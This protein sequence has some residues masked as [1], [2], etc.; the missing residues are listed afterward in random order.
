MPNTLRIKRRSAGGSSGSPASLEQAELAYNESD[1]GNGILYIGIGTGG[2]GGSA[3]SIVPIGGD[4]AYCTLSG[5][6]T[7]SGNKTFSG[8]VALGGSAT[9]TTPATGDN[10]TSVATTGF[11]KAQ[12]YISANQ[13]ITLSGDLT[14]SGTTS[15]AGTLATVNS[16]PGTTSGVT[17]NAKGLVTAIAALQASDLPSITAAKVSDFD[18]VVQAN[19]LDEMAAPTS[20]VSFN[21]QEIT[22]VADPTSAQ[23]AATKAYVDAVKTGLDVKDSVRAATTANITLANTQTIDGVS[24]SAGD[25]VL[26]KNQSTA[27]E[28]GLYVVVDGGS[29]TRATD[30]DSSTEVTSG[31]FVFVEA[32]SAN[33][34][35][36]FTLTTDGSIT[37]GTTGLAFT[38]F[39]GAGSI[40]AGT[41]LSKSGTTI[42]A[43]I[44]SNGG[45]VTES[46][47]LAVDLGASS[48]TG[49]LAVSDGGTGA[50]SVSAA[51]QALDLEPGVDV[52]AQNAI[53]SDLAGLTQAANKL[54]FFDSGST[55]ATTDLT[56]FARTLLDDGSASAVQ[57]TLSL[58]PGTNIQSFDAGLAS[59]AGLTTSA[60]KGIYA[61]ASDTYATFDLTA[62]G[63][64]ILDDADAAAVR[65]TLGLVIN[66]DVQG[67]SSVT[68]TLAGLSSADGNFIVGN[69][70]AF[71]V[72]SGAT[73]RTTLGLGSIATQAANSVALTG[74]TISSGVTI[75]GG[76]F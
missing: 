67:F 71:T 52:Q 35:A 4:G 32:G 25:R 23:S 5:N 53:L 57:T 28:N 62:F 20:S 54:P 15:I 45:I 42:S 29:W 21:S 55:A 60:N 61:T 34:D 58:V 2:S 8:T 13:T 24:L 59:I 70:S 22:N 41:G 37:V 19:R 17:V 56:A 72:E 6:Q 43:D 26:V 31:A 40:S 18:S 48:I 51:Q 9:A 63:R 16:S 10:D 50:T 3:T 7:L 47:A 75:D 49:T 14:G 74:G 1:A 66:T 65:T 76:T 30:F 46:N 33:S 12:N 69:G 68:S 11:V 27:S 38:Q 36:G 39:S 73:A 44:K 64:S